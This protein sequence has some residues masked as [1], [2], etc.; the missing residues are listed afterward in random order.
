MSVEGLK[1]G[2]LSDADARASGY[3]PRDIIVA[4]DLCKK[5][6]IDVRDAILAV[7]DTAR[8][9]MSPETHVAVSESIIASAIV[10]ATVP[11]ALMVSVFRDENSEEVTPEDHAAALLYMI[12]R[13]E[14][15]ERGKPASP[16]A[17]LAIV[18]KMIVVLK[19]EGLMQ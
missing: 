4:Q 2:R 12:V 9:V 5:V 11:L 17:V 10:S 8:R 6:A 19:R 3:E 15:N 7:A 13:T 18:E 16:N 14:A 1:I